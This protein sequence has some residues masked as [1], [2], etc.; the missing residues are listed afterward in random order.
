M[1]HPKGF[2]HATGH[3]LC[4][5]G[6]GSV[7]RHFITAEEEKKQLEEYKEQLKKELQGV[8]ECIQDIKDK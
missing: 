5:C 1:G 6:C 2:H 7:F 4:H 3:D 8:E